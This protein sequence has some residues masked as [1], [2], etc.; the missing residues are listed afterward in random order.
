MNGAGDTRPTEGDPH[1]VRTTFLSQVGHELRTPL[2]LMLGPLEHLLRHRDEGVSSTARKDLVVVHRNAV[3]LLR[4]VNALVEFSHLDA[5]RIEAMYEPTDLAELTGNLASNFRS[6]IEGFGLRFVVGR[7]ELRE[8]VY[9]DHRIWEK[10]V[11]HL[12]SNAVEHT[13]NGEIGIAVRAVGSRAELVVRDTGIGIPAEQLPHIFECFHR[14]PNA[15]SR[16]QAGAGIG[17]ALVREL[18]QQHGGDVRVESVVGEGTI[19]VAAVPFGS[20]HL[21]PDRVIGA[22]A[23]RSPTSTMHAATSLVHEMLGWFSNAAEMSPRGSPSQGATTAAVVPTSLA[24]RPAARGHAS[25]SYRSVDGLGD[26]AER[27][28]RILIAD[29]NADM[30]QFIAGLL[31]AQ[32]EVEAVADGAAGLAAARERLPDLVLS[33]VMMP[34]LDGFGLLRELRADPRTQT[35]PVILVSA[36]SGEESRVEGLDVGADDYLEKPFTTR[37][38]VARVNSTLRLARMRRA[39]VEHEQRT[40][41]AEAANEAKTRFLTTMSHELRTPL[42]AIGG[43]VDLLEMGLYGPITGEQQGVLKHVRRSGQRLL[44]L[45]TNILNFGQLEAG[46]VQYQ[47]RDVSVHDLLAD[48]EGLIEPQVRAKNITYTCIPPRQADLVLQTDPD[49]VTQIVLNL[50][51]NAVKFTGPGGRVTIT[52]SVSCVGEETEGTWNRLHIA[53]TDTG[54]GIP[55]DKLALVFEPFV[56]LDRQ[57]VHESQQGVGLGLAIS[58]DLAR[59]LGGDLTAESVERQGSTFCVVLPR[60]SSNA[61]RSVDGQGAAAP[62][63]DELTR[64]VTR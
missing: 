16:T 60:W 22:A 37:E 61:M 42:N 34:G 15:K 63:S 26:I 12:L 31:G 23:A 44:A 14:V 5:G 7:K 29:D 54:R 35:V 57:L 52:C 28:A 62:S 21:P 40:S 2:T 41:V 59:Q 38:L 4:M 19:V 6:L 8:P 30:R 27:R 9:V 51:S 1:A 45:I 55:Q 50:L 25:T 56:Q 24:E 33:D 58:R 20:E 11:L 39:V 43:Y 49:R 46:K 17:L 53:V 10:I 36:R 47:M 18:V 3:R 13:F 64:A 32:Y 48:L